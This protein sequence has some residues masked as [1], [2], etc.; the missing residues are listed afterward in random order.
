[1]SYPPPAAK[2][3]PEE[4]RLATI[5]E[6]GLPPVGQDPRPFDLLTAP[7]PQTPPAQAQLAEPTQPA[8]AAQA[9]EPVQPIQ[10]PA[11]KPTPLLVEKVAN[12][13]D[14][15]APNMPP[16]PDQSPKLSTDLMATIE[17]PPPPDESP[18]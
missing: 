15:L 2:P 1:M 14:D 18:T 13:A 5:E 10:S 3:P 11:G 7:G 16:P 12:Q 17:G 8:P 6:L 9:V 4:H